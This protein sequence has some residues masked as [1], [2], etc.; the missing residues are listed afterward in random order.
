MENLLRDLKK[1]LE[2]KTK[3]YENTNTWLVDG[4]SRLTIGKSVNEYHSL[5]TRLA[6]LATIAA[7]INIIQD[8]IDMIEIDLKHEVKQ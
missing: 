8:H 7:E 5:Q 1:E 2:R 4:F 3:Q 6:E